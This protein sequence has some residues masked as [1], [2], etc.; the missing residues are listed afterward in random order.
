MIT[1]CFALMCKIDN[2]FKLLNSPRVL[3]WEG[4]PCC[5][6]FLVLGE[7]SVMLIVFC[8]GRWIRA[9]HRF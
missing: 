5:S 9:A 2:I 8:F 4:D 1:I 3:F 6:S 7:G